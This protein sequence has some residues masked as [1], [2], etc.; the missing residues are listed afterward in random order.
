M[1]RAGI[2]YMSTGVFLSYFALSFAF[3]L[4]ATD[5][6]FLTTDRWPYAQSFYFPFRYLTIHETEKLGKDAV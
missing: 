5:D 6:I 3:Y 2:F 4:S 1:E